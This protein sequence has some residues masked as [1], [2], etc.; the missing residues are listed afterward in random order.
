MILFIITFAFFFLI[1]G[2]FVYLIVNSNTD[3]GIKS[4][5][6]TVL[7]S[8]ALSLIFTL[9]LW[10]DAA[11][12]DK[13]WNDGVCSY[14]NTKWELVSVDKDRYGDKTYYYTCPDCGTII[15]Q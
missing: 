6:T 13:A 7:I 9:G 12:K 11:V 3:G 4:I 5:V 15:E 1:F 2:C 10:A 8:S 14:C